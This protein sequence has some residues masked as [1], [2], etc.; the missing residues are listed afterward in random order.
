[1]GYHGISRAVKETGGLPQ[2]RRDAPIRGHLAVVR[3]K[4]PFGRDGVTDEPIATS[5]LCD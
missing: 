3:L 1:M 5:G 4:N 2:A